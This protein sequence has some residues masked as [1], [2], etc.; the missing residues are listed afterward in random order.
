MRHWLSHCTR[1]RPGVLLV[2]LFLSA[3]SHTPQTERLLSQQQAFQPPSAE[4]TDVPF[5]PQTA[6]QCG[7]AAL[8]TVM[9]YRQ[10]AIE[11]D[12][13]VP[14]V[15]IPEK[16]GSVQIEMVA[17]TRRQGLMPTPIDGTLD[18][19]LTEVA[20]GNPVLVMQ[21]LGY[22]WAPVW[23]YAVV[24][25]YDINAQQLILRSA[26]TR[27]WQ[28][29]FKTFE[30]TWARSEHWGLVITQPDKIPATASRVDW[31]KTAYSLEETGQIQAAETAY[32]TGI[33]HWPEHDQMAIALANLFFNQNDNMKAGETYRS[34]IAA[35]PRNAML[36]NNLAYVLQARQC[37]DAALDAAQCAQ[38]LQPD[39]ANIADTVDE[40]R[41]Q[42]GGSNQCEIPAC[43]AN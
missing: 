26:E 4:L 28:T 12:T 42:T 35:S 27:R 32:R 36:W 41:R 9:N 21:N 23:H 38:Q 39:D 10:V 22:N 2:L 16:Q 25:G 1:P 18:S 24:I 8:A 40:M 43:P 17:A 30:R 14:Q 33:R 37:P 31:L 20:A 11:P 19:L 15:Y 29:P 6:Y 7:P 5:F 3:C 34:L 13:L